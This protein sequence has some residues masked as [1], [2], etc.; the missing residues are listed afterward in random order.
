MSDTTPTPEQDDP[1]GVDEVTE[2]QLDADNEVEEDTLKT[3]DP[4]DSPA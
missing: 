3:L 2:N 4:D 1:T